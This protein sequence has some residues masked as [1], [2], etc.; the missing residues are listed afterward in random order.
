MWRKLLYFDGVKSYSYTITGIRDRMRDRNCLVRSSWGLVKNSCGGFS[1]VMWPPSIKMTWLATSSSRVTTTHGHSSWASCFMT[2]TS[3]TSSGS[4]LL[5]SSS[6]M[7]SGLTAMARAQS[8]A[9][10]HLIASDSSPC[11]LCPTRFKASS[12]ISRSSLGIYELPLS[13]LRYSFAAVLL[14]KILHWRCALLRDF[15]N[16]L[17]SLAKS[18]SYSQSQLAAIRFF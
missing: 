5:D 13:L 3:P 12:A 7:T 15:Q 10:G 17:L 9:A 18:Q 14:V 2:L 6:R 4:R 11:K 1:S 16:L 8:A